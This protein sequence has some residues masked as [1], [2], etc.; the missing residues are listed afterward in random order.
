MILAKAPV[1]KLRLGRP[2]RLPSM[3]INFETD[4]CLCSSIQTIIYSG[5]YKSETLP[6]NSTRTS[7]SICHCPTIY[8]QLSMSPP[9]GW[10]YFLSSPIVPTC[11]TPFWTSIV[12]RVTSAVPEPLVTHARPEEKWRKGKEKTPAK[13]KV[14]M[15]PA[16]SL[17]YT[18]RGYK[19][20]TES[21]EDARL[22]EKKNKPLAKGKVSLAPATSL[23]YALHGYKICRWE[24]TGC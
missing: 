23:T 7:I 14:R 16:A 3:F 11:P 5:I 24:P 13:G 9:S 19:V 21:W 1:Y 4:P 12:A 2:S 8:H 6:S 20:V 10:L 18:L 17:T 22:Q 15:V